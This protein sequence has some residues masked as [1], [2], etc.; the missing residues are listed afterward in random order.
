[1]KSHWEADG[2]E[3]REGERVESRNVV[4]AVLA[5]PGKQGKKE[6]LPAEIASIHDDLLSL[7]RSQEWVRLLQLTRP[8]LRGII[9]SRN[10]TE[11]IDSCCSLRVDTSAR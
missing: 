8:L 10:E 4:R 7:T 5:R 1:M 9:V 3:L 6:C 2:T 11:G